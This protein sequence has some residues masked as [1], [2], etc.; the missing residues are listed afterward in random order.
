M[1]DEM[2]VM[3]SMTL[4]EQRAMNMCAWHDRAFVVFS[5]IVGQRLIAI[6]S[7]GWLKWQKESSSDS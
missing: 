1:R 6:L 2:C 4:G 5:N 7:V 3:I